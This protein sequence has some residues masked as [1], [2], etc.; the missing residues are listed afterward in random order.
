MTGIIP[1]EKINEIRGSIDIVDVIGEYVH[2]KKQGRNYFG[3]CPFHGEN[4]PSF[5]VSSDKQIFHC[6][7]CGAGGNVFTFIMDIDGIGF[8]EAVIKLAQKANIELSIDPKI[9]QRSEGNHTSDHQKMLEAHALL[10]KFY[11]HLLVNTKE[12]QEA[13]EYLIQRGFT[14][15]SMEKFQIGY[16]LPSWDFTVKLFQKRG[17]PLPLMEKAGL[18]IKK[19]SDDTYFDR[20]RNRIMFPIMNSKGQTIA[21]SGR[22]LDKEE[23]P[24][25][26]NSPETELFNKSSVLYN[27]HQARSFIKKQQQA[28]LFEGFADCISADRASIYNGIATMGTAL[29]EQH[30]QQI[31]RLTDNIIICYDSDSAGTEAAYKAGQMLVEHHFNIR[32]ARMPD[33]LD[34]DDYIQKNSAEKFR[35][36]VIGASMTFMAFKMQYHRIGKK[37]QNEGEKLKYIEIIINE[38]SKLENAVERDHYLRQLAEEFSISMDALKQQQ[39]HAFYA[40]KKKN[41]FMGQS[42]NHKVLVK[43]E[44]KILPAHQTAERRLLSHMLR[45]VEIAYKVRDLL[46]NHTFN[47][48]EH[49]AILTYLLGFYEEGNEP[50]TS[51]FL[52]YLPDQQLRRVVADIEMMPL[53]SEVSNQEIEDYIIQVLKHQKMLKINEKVK[54]Q[55]K[56]ELE[57]DLQ[58]ALS[59]ANEIIQLRK[60]L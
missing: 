48:D 30:V 49:Q 56:A 10:Q 28:I 16:A 3:L 50:D 4:T 25:Y 44:K 36:D 24:K 7:G 59:I 18:I 22:V 21:F 57:N 35:Q 17:F 52:L 13:F 9:D 38:I 37:L 58:K 47:I 43:Q 2:L 5:S 41:S 39:L 34:P 32:I 26:L 42:T 54:E 53:N 46:A 19:E 51:S 11:H 23:Q 27:L 15:E 60:S 31:R 40:N 45:D 33:G 6:F 8:Q 29:T 12:G 20:F 1:E 14:R 55:K